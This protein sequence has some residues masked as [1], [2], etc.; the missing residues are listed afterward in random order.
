MT[1]A[2]PNSEVCATL[3]PARVPSPAFVV[4]LSRLRRNLE[5][6]R[7]VKERAGCRILL[8]QKGFSMWAVY[9]LIA[10]YLDGT[11]S[12]GPWEA[13][14]AKEKFPGGEVHVYSPAYTA[15]DLAE[16][17]GFA[18]H[19][20]FNSVR[21]WRQAKPAIQ[22][23]GRHIECALRVNPGVSTGADHAAACANDTATS[24][25]AIGTNRETGNRRRVLVNMQD[26]SQSL[27]TS[28]GIDGSGRA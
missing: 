28:G 11:C 3:D 27:G 10:Q 12:S 15:A 21:Q 14:L 9:P 23:S 2:G 26:S 4:D 24:A 18:D 22:A 20:S 16:I 13:L 19:L 5:F 17:T 7:A 8:A 25:T 1:I 6:L